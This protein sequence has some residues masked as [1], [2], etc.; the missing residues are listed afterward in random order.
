MVQRDPEIRNAA[1]REYVA[2]KGKAAKAKAKLAR[3]L[4][5][6][7][8]ERDDPELRR[9]RVANNV[10]RT[11]ENTREWVGGPVAGD[12]EED[13][14]KAASG[15]EGEDSDDEDIGSD[16]DDE[17]DDEMQEDAPAQSTSTSKGPVVT[18]GDART[19]PVQIKSGGSPE[20]FELDMAG[21]EDLF[22]AHDE[23]NALPPRASTSR[24]PPPKPLLLT[25]SPRPHGPTYE[26][27]NELQSLLGG[28]RYAQILPRKNARFEL[29]KV[30]KW[31]IK[32][33]Y[34][35]IAVVGED[36]HGEPGMLLRYTT[37]DGHRFERFT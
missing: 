5:Q 18:E 23:A 26:F 11:I 4:A 8:A 20:D 28:K 30:C 17:D 24:L 7:K 25:T 16:I 35:G 36:F 2:Q 27:L 32:R 21:L 29:S 1:R 3:R 31:A 13:R 22:S 6:K 12:D 9:V 19:R 33:G 15:S 34:G 10:P 37:N 14:K